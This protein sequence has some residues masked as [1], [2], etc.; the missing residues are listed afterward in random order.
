MDGKNSRLSFVIFETALGWM[1]VVCSPRGV[2]R[3]MLPQQSK[4]AVLS[5]AEGYEQASEFCGSPAVADLVKRLRAYLEGQRVDFSDRLDL[6][7]ATDFQQSVWRITRKIPCGET[8]S[9]AWIASQAARPGAARAVGRAMA[10]NPVPIVIP[11]HRVVGSNGSLVGF[12]GGLEMK[13][14]LLEMEK[15]ARIRRR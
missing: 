13:K 5:Q 15:A 1:G 8:R 4:E 2:R 7:G 14:R 10:T 9:Y 6:S 11:C 12:G 3:L